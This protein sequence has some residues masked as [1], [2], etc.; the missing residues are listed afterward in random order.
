MKFLD[1]AI[2]DLL[3]IFQ[4]WKPAIFL[5][6]APVVFTLMFGFMFGGFS[7][8][9]PETADN[10]LPVRLVT[11][12]ETPITESFLDYLQSSQA[13]RVEKLEGEVDLAEQKRAVADQEVAA[14]ILLSK[15]FSRIV[16][17]ESRIPMDVI[18]DEAATTGIAIQQ[19]LQSS[20]SR[21][22]SAANVASLAVETYDEKGKGSSSEAERES[23][24]D[25][26]FEEALSAWQNPPVMGKTFQTAPDGEQQTS[27]ENAFAQSLPGMMS[28]FAIAGLIGAAEIIV[29]ERKSGAL[30][31]LLGTAVSKPAILAG[32][33][34]AMFGMIFLQFIVLVA[35]GQ[36]F[37]KLDFL[38]SPLAT[39]LLSIAA[40]AFTASLG[41]LIGILAKIPEQT[42]VFAL[43]PM[44]L[45]S[46]LGGAWVPFDILGETVRQVSQFT[47]VYWIMTGFKDILLRGAGMDTV[48][49]SIL[50]LWGFSVL[51]FIPAAVLFNR[52]RIT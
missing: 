12:E 20:A 5:V 38:G 6:A 47:P 45:F 9:S 24:Y 29:Q 10:R 23:F 22:K 51:F 3:Q 52:K 44:F 37:L 14:V 1:L 41:L 13:I 42:A 4:D 16:R 32:H 35:F 46:G 34:L 17:E 43:I 11:Q 8:M 40:C 18:L 39:L 48:W 2:K 25:L 15:D 31:R 27:E 36:I 21:L 49:P 19:E 26:A 28:Q 50:V 33:W 7:G 30:D